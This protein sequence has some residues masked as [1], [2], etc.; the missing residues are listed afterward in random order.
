MHRISQ[1]AA[2]HQLNGTY[3]R[4]IYDNWLVP[5]ESVSSSLA[6]PVN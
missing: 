3:I 4:L 1:L 5:Y 6:A 2:S